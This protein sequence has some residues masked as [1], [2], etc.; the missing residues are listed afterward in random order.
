[1]TSGE[2]FVLWLWYLHVAFFWIKGVRPKMP[3]GNSVVE[4][5]RLAECVGEVRLLLRQILSESSRYCSS[6]ARKDSKAGSQTAGSGSCGALREKILDE[7]HTTFTAC[8][9]AFYPTNNLKW[10]CLCKLLSSS[11]PVSNETLNVCAGFIVHSCSL[12]SVLMLS[13]CQILVIV[14]LSCY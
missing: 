2:Y 12:F 1:M 8:F 10:S 4:T 3:H 5:P 9:H 7:C 14:R 13:A 6:S 11:D